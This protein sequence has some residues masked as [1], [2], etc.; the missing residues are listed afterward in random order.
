MLWRCW[1]GGRKGIRPVNTWV[2]GCWRGY[3]SVARCR[4]AYGHSLSLA[5]VKSRLVLP[6]WYRLSRVVL[7]KGPGVTYFLTY[8]VCGARIQWQWL[9]VCAVTAMVDSTLTHWYWRLRWTHHLAAERRLT[10]PTCHSSHFFLDRS[11]RCFA[12][13]AVY[14]FWIV[15]A[16]SFS[17]FVFSYYYYSS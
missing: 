12:V 13:S 6:F 8:C 9:A 10:S 5:S 16:C 4:L 7:D 1:L 15:S 3:L 11:L 17:S 14:Q 2:V